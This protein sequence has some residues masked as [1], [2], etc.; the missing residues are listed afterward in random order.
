MRLSQSLRIELLSIQKYCRDVAS[1]HNAWKEI[2]PHRGDIDFSEAYQLFLSI[3]SDNIHAHKNRL[4]AIM[5]LTEKKSEKLDCLIYIIQFEKILCKFS[6][7]E[8]LLEYCRIGMNLDPNNP[9]F[10]HSS[11]L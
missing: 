6:S 4:E 5:D 11:G 3:H 1:H 9:F 10:I 8:Q 7:K 2:Y